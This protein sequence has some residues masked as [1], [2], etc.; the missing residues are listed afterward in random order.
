LLYGYLGLVVPNCDNE[1]NT[2]TVRKD[3]LVVIGF[4]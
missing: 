1:Q 4:L 2:V 3:N